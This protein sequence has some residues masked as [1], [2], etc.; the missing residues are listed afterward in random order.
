MA[1]VRIDFECLKELVGKESILLVADTLPTKEE[2]KLTSSTYLNLI[3]Q[4]SLKFLSHRRL[5]TL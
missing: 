5:L 2:A 3:N 4:S 1:K